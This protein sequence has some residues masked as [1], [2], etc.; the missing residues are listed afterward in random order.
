M[1]TTLFLAFLAAVAT[2]F[3]VGTQG[4]FTSRA[5]GIVDPLRVS[6]FVHIGGTFSAGLLLGLV[7]LR[8]G[9]GFT[10][11]YSGPVIPYTYIAGTLG[12][13]II[14][15]IAFAFPTIGLTAG[16]AAFLLG[17]MLIA[18][19]VD[20]AGLAGRDGIPL[21]LRRIAGLVLLAAAA[22][23]LLPRDTG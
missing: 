22:W 8:A 6:F 4:T 12:V 16:Q 19:I 14:M 10:L 3:A 2:G 18:I 7:A 1:S 5:G 17:Q 21:D 23:L 20:T 11:G 15:G 13:F 9:P